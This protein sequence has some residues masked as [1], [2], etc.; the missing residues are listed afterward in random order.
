[1]ANRCRILDFLSMDGCVNTI[2]FS[3]LAVRIAVCSKERDRTHCVT[4]SRVYC[5]HHWNIVRAKFM[6]RLATVATVD[7]RSNRSKSAIIPRISF[8]WTALPNGFQ[9][10]SKWKDTHCPLL[11]RLMLYATFKSFCITICQTAYGFTIESKCIPY[12]IHSIVNVRYMFRVQT[13]NHHHI[14]AFL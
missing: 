12:T 6:F 2:L 7:A 10:V 3:I 14:M 1:M 13:H 4:L 5:Q 8:S 9:I 11:I